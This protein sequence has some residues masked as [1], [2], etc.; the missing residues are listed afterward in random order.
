MFCLHEY[1]GTTCMPG[2]YRGKKRASDPPE[3][4]L[5]MIGSH[6][7]VLGIKPRSFVSASAPIRS[8][9]SPAP[10]L[11]MRMCLHKCVH[12]CGCRKTAMTGSWEL[13]GWWVLGTE[14]GSSIRAALPPL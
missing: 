10:F 2:A 1:L 5:Q 14:P 9:V 12:I 11:V 13:P 8:V 4:E 6:H 3:K 7:M